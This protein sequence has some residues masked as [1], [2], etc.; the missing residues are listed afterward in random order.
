[1]SGGFRGRGGLR[2]GFMPR[3]GG[4]GFRGG[5]RGGYMGG[6]GGGMGMGMGMGMGGA[7]RGGRNFSNDLYADYNG[8][9]GSAANGGM[10]VDGVGSGLQSEPAE[11]NQQ[12]LVRN[13]SLF[14]HQDRTH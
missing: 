4:F 8:P 5:L 13:V 11:P 3:G 10:A 12:I 2:G 14:S 7:G 1:M 9:E 6:G